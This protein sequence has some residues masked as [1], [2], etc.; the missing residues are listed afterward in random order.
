MSRF[1]VMLLGAMLVLA[2]PVFADSAVMG[3]WEGQFMTDGWKDVPLRAEIIG[4]AGDTYRVLLHVGDASQGELSGMSRS[5]AFVHIGEIEV[6]DKGVFLVTASGRNGALTGTLMAKEDAAAA[7]VVF[8]M[9]KVTRQSPTLGKAA[10]KGAVVLLGEGAAADAW[11]AQPGNIVDGEMRIGGNTYTTKQEFGSAQI[12]VEFVSPYMPDASGQARGNSGVYV[13]GR[14]E[15]QVLDS[16]ADAPGVGTCGA[17]YSIAV[18]PAGACLPPGEWQ[19]YDITFHA[20]EFDAGGKKVK[21]ATITVIQNGQT[22]YDNLAL[23]H[24]T[25]GGV[26]GD[27]SARGPLML[28]NHGNEVH[29]RN[30]WVQPLDK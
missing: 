18:P 22:I 10:P 3:N 23:P 15:V 13:A 14:Y 17:I 8:Q 7:P 4:L 2:A 28:Q 19:T 25:P 9:Q 11:I 24:V 27:E 30:V 29:Y 6:K 12:H 5:G 1:A 26:S 16:F 21:D 20:P